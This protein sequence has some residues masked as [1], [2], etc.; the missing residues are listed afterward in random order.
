MRRLTLREANRL[1]RTIYAELRFQAIYSLRQGNL[2]PRLPAR[3]LVIRAERQVFQSKIAVAF[4]LGLLQLGTLALLTPRGE[5]L[6]GP[7]VPQPVYV[8]TVLGGLW[9]I[10]LSLLWTEGLQ[11]LPTFL[12][13]RAVSLLE[14][15]PIPRRTGEEASMLA[16]LRLFDV[17]ALVAIFGPAF[18]IGVALSSPWAAIA[19]VPGGVAVVLI[20]LVLSLATGGFFVRHLASAPGG[21][22]STVVRWLF[23]LAG[24][25]P[26]LGLYAFF[27]FAPPLM[28]ALGSL[29]ANHSS[30]V[31]ALLLLFPFAFAALPGATTG[32]TLPPPLAGPLLGVVLA[33]YVVI[34]AAGASWLVGAPRRLS[35]GVADATAR[36]SHGSRLRTTG[37]GWAVFRKD[38]RVASRTPGY[39]FLILLPL[40]DAAALGLATFSLKPDPSTISSLG[41]AAVSSSEL[42]A[43]FFAPAFF[44]T[45][46]IGLSYTRALPLTGRS[47]LTGKLALVL[48]I[49]L[50][51]SAI[52][53][54]LTLLR[55]FEPVFLLLFVAGGLPGLLAASCCEL[56]LL[57]R[58]AARTGL[59]SGQL[60]GGGWWMIAVAIPGLLV[61][62][63]PLGSYAYVSAH[64]GAYLGLAALA[65]VGS[66]ELLIMLPLALLAA[67]D[68]VT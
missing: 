59:V 45:E 28:A 1:S 27:S 26:A 20:G 56:G 30:A 6:L 13:S 23:L 9:L 2:L 33:G 14:T 7:G 22:R 12:S 36:P 55:L 5:L 49:Y 44:A 67:R 32:L 31:G 34:F 10:E 16:V 47:L 37:P 35:L 51:S 66:A 60:F 42:L 54:V 40:L 48:L 29:S 68:V 62:A 46:V 57:L 24:T 19:A 4:L 21:R 17:P 63:V 61:A 18:V 3:E 65:L 53:L 43:I 15:L 39:G 8:A 58:R 50:L 64:A 11:I 38:L 41:S 25:V 52:V